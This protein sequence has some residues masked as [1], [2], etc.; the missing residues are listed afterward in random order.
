MTTR[1]MSIT[2]VVGYGVLLYIMLML[3]LYATTAGLITMAVVWAVY[4]VAYF[5]AIRHYA[6]DGSNET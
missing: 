6:S 5:W 2:G 1:A 4:T 3:D